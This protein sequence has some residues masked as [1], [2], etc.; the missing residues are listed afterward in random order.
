MA[1][2]EKKTYVILRVCVLHPSQDVAR[3]REHL[4][5]VRAK[6]KQ[7]QEEVDEELGQL[8]AS[9]ENALVGL[10]IAVEAAERRK[11]EEE[12][13]RKKKMAIIVAEKKANVERLKKG[14]EEKEKEAN[15]LKKK[16]KEAQRELEEAEIAARVRISGCLFLLD[17]SLAV[18]RSFHSTVDML[19]N[20]VYIGVVCALVGFS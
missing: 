11:R 18:K 10:D 1:Q 3:A 4:K 20:G 12:E 2:S 8:L 17:F 13:E 19:L 16:A 14:A 7:R 6:L 9:E 5:G 15:E